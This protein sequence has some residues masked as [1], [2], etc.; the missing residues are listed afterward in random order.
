MHPAIDAHSHMLCR[1]WFE[2]LKAHGAPRFTV[3]PLN[4]NDVI[5]HDG[6]PLMAPQPQMFDYDYRIKAMD[7]AK[8][9]TAIL[10]LTGPNVYWG[11][12]AVSAQAARTMNESFAAAQA[13][14]PQ[15]IRW[16]ASLPFEYPKRAVAELERAL[17]TGAV[18]VVVL[19]NVGG[20]PLTDPLFEPIWRAI[21]DRALAV[22]MHPTVPCG[23]GMMGVERYQLTASVAF[24]FDT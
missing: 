2:L 1:E 21:D 5:H 6:V 17:D 18:G 9:S 15:R 7:E 19:S 16:L 23:C 8:V 11:D 24:P 3:K 13:A 12:E 14:H 20:K 22:F 4:G 10:S